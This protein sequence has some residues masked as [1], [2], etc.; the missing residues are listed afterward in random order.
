[1]PID[2]ERT[3]TFAVDEACPAATDEDFALLEHATSASTAANTATSA[4][5][6]GL[7]LTSSGAIAVRP[8]G[9]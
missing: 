4:S 5:L 3:V 6:S 7:R 2:V 8:P 1:M 9:S